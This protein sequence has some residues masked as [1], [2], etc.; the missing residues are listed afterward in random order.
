MLVK[1]L[2]Y[3]TLALVLL[4]LLLFALLWHQQRQ[5]RRLQQQQMQQL[6]KQLLV[7]RSEIKEIRTALFALGRKVNGLE[8]MTSEVSERQEE[9]ELVE[10]DSKLYTRAVKMV[11]LGASVDE[12]MAECEL[13]QAEAELIVSLH[14]SN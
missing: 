3:L 2:P 10:P 6:S 11:S 9:L 7:Y 4:L 1:L 12:V 13:P 14:K 5:S 8:S